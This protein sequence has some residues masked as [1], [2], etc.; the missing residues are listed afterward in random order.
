M[1]TLLQDSLHLSG[2]ILCCLAAEMALDALEIN[3]K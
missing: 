2:I 1:E 3:T